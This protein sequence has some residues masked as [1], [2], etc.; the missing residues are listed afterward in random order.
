MLT[1]MAANVGPY[2]TA[3]YWP[4]KFSS[5]TWMVRRLSLLVKVSAMSRSFQ[6]KKNCTRPTVKIALRT[7]GT[8]IDQNDRYAGAVDGG[9]LEH[10]A[11]YGAEV[12]RHH[13]HRQGQA[14][15]GRSHHVATPGIQGR[16]VPHS[17]AVDPAGRRHR[18]T[19]VCTSVSGWSPISRPASSRRWLS[20]RS[21]IADPASDE[22][23]LLPTGPVVL[24]LLPGNIPAF[25][26]NA[27]PGW[28]A[29]LSQRSA[30]D[31]RFL[32][33][34]V[35]GRGA[36]AVLLRGPRRRPRLHIANDNLGRSSVP[37]RSAG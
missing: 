34:R 21:Q 16:I 7:I 2:W 14:G 1:Q 32:P 12:G 22:S 13:E 30:R 3:P 15:G 37:R 33:A 10:F 4:V 20:P 6:R 23:S 24:E 17:D 19:G 31:R 28:V 11:W 26:M 29:W 5:P 36:R 35:P 25:G 27:R 18:S 8:P 9:R